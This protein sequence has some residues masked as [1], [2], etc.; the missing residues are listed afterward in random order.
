MKSEL[1]S[2]LGSGSEPQR[3]KQVHSFQEILDDAAKKLAEEPRRVSYE[4]KTLGKDFHSKCAWGM[5]PD[6]KPVQ[7]FESI[8]REEQRKEEEAIE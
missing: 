7:D 6:E 8:L 4:D 3:V 5:Q 1:W 2:Y